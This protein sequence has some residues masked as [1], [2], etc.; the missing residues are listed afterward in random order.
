M[1]SWNTSLLLRNI[2]QEI[3]LI[4]YEIEH[5]SGGIGPI[6][7]QGPKGD[8]GAA[9]A[10]P[11]TMTLGG[12][13]QVYNNTLTSFIFPSIVPVT[14]QTQYIVSDQCYSNC[15]TSCQYFKDGNT[16]FLGLRDNKI[17]TDPNN[18]QA[19]CTWYFFADYA[20]QQLYQFNNT[21]NMGQIS[22]TKELQTFTM[23]V[24]NGSLKCYLNNAE[25]LE[26]QRTVSPS[27]LWYSYCSTY[28]AGAYTDNIVTDYI[29]NQ[30]VPGPQ[31]A[32]GAQGAQGN[33]GIQGAKGD[34]GDTGATG[35]KGDTGATG[36]KGDNGGIINTLEAYYQKSLTAGID[37]NPSTIYNIG[38]I[39]L[40]GNYTKVNAFLN[41]LVITGTFTGPL[42]GASNLFFYLGDTTT[43]NYNAL[44]STA[45]SLTLPNQSAVPAPFSYN[46]QFGNIPFS[47]CT[48]T[49]AFNTVHLLMYLVNPNSPSGAINITNLTYQ[50]MLEAT[51]P[52]VAINLS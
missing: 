32:Q 9:G 8:T 33:Q 13:A 51:N 30:E 49:T 19:S 6:G 44:L 18:P 14:S 4:N 52:A 2:Q 22:L 7:P 3:D 38:S 36:A 1:A 11:F 21:A 45:Y 29:F 17:P 12:G 40:N 48:N 41:T 37:L 35:A 28:N 25:I 5:S 31:G 46:L 34:K 47:F 39:N 16:L 23:S 27:T 15:T 43:T 50:M 24:I 10:S 42:I 26:F 20:N